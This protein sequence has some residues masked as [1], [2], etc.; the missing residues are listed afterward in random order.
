MLVSFLLVGFCCFFSLRPAFLSL[1][2]RM[3][4]FGRLGPDPPISVGDFLHCLIGVDIWRLRGALLLAMEREALPRHSG[5]ITSLSMP[6]LVHIVIFMMVSCSHVDEYYCMM[7]CHVF[8]VVSCFLFQFSSWCSCV[9]FLFC[10]LFVFL[11]LFLPPVSPRL[12]LLTVRVLG[13]GVRRL[14]VHGGFFSVQ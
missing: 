1:F 2:S 8:S 6:S 4:V 12:S 9:C 3:V 13:R 11:F 10:F 7:V 5:L 14:C